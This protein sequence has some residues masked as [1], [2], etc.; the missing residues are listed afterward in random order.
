MLSRVQFALTA[1]IH[2]LYPPLSIG[3]GLV[4]VCVEAL[5]LKT[6]NQSST[7]WRDSGRRFWR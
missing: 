3:L 2:Y 5:W 7:R 4:L 6:R 1:A